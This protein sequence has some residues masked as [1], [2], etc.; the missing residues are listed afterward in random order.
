VCALQGTAVKLN[1][2]Q[3]CWQTDEGSHTQWSQKQK[4]VLNGNSGADLNLRGEPV[5]RSSP[6]T[7]IQLPPIKGLRV[8]KLGLKLAGSTELVQCNL[9]KKLGQ[10]KCYCKLHLQPHTALNTAEDKTESNGAHH[11]VCLRP[12]DCN[13]LCTTAKLTPGLTIL[14]APNTDRSTIVE[15]ALSAWMRMPL[16]TAAQRGQRCAKSFTHSGLAAPLM[17][18]LVSAMAPPWSR[19][20]PRMK[21][22]SGMRTPAQHARLLLWPKY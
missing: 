17:L 1:W 8:S 11:S 20:T 2:H 15:P 5:C 7:R 4:I 14:K 12:F 6:T 18:A 22:E 10:K 13:R 19:H 21:V 9:V 3:A 16:K